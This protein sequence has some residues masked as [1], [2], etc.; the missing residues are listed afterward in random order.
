VTLATRQTAEGQDHGG[1]D[2]HYKA[3][4]SLRKGS[5]ERETAPYC[6][7]RCVCGSATAMIPTS[8][9]A[10]MG[11]AGEEETEQA[12]LEPELAKWRS[13]E[14]QGGIER[15]SRFEMARVK[16]SR[17][18]KNYLKRQFSWTRFATRN[19]AREKLRQEFAVLFAISCCF[20]PPSLTLRTLEHCP[21]RVVLPLLHLKRTNY[22]CF[23]TTRVSFHSVCHRRSREIF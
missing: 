8:R 11:V 13:R 18:S 10:D 14:E 1:L 16:I 4:R 6:S 12:P 20:F 5:R 3:V 17:V 19:D 7:T 15:R 21:L 22:S 9:R 2:H 23:E